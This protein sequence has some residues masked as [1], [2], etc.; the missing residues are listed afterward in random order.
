MINKVRLAEG[1][2]FAV[3][4]SEHDKKVEYSVTWPEPFQSPLCEGLDVY[5]KRALVSC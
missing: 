3:C 2:G 1:G 5:R 4:D